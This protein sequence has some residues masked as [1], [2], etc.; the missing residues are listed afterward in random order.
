TLSPLNS[1]SPS[2]PQ[3]ARIVTSKGDPYYLAYRTPIGYDGY[4]GST[5]YTSGSL[6]ETAIH[7]W[8]GGVTNT[9]YIGSV[10]A[11][12]TFA[13]AGTTLTIVQTSHS[14]TGPPSTVYVGITPPTGLKATAGNAQVALS[15][16]AAAGATGYN[17]KRAPSSGGPYTTIV[18][19]GAT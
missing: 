18:T 7:R 1:Q 13:D 14:G 6:N 12:D 9:R 2:G 11:G 4:L 8:P 19:L 17:V 5:Y 16:T 3:V 10:G 15:W